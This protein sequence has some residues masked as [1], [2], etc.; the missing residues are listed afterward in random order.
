MPMAEG[1]AIAQLMAALH[2]VGKDNVELV[3]QEAYQ[4]DAD[5][6]ISVGG[7]SL[8]SA[9]AGILRAGFPRFSIKYPEH[10]ASYG[11]TTFSP[12]ITSSGELREDYGFLACSRPRPDKYCI[13][14]C[15]VWAAGTQMAVSALVAAERKSEIRKRII[16]RETFFAVMHGEVRGLA[17][18][19][20][21]TVEVRSVGA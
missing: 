17:Q 14:V 6:T 9:S 12:E 1:G 19:S 13:V 21:Q 8:N 2:A 4:N 5:V 20:V 7:P 15:G 18:E 11:T 16:G 3:P 10:I